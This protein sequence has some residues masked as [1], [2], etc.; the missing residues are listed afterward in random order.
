MPREAPVTNAYF[1][2]QDFLKPTKKPIH[3]NGLPVEIFIN[4][5]VIV[6]FRN[7]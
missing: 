6:S 1:I 4:I 2:F 3:A 7:M 5:F